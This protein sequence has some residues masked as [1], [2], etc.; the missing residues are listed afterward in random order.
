MKHVSHIRYLHQRYIPWWCTIKDLQES[1]ILQ[2]SN[3]SS[4][5]AILQGRFRL[6]RFERF[7]YPPTPALVPLLRS[8]SSSCRHGCSSRGREID[9]IGP[10][11]T[12]AEGFGL[13]LSRISLKDFRR[14][15]GGSGPPATTT[16]W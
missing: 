8:P 3:F 4:S 13:R 11:F 5:S 6:S 12:A 14:V 10:G 9:P 1:T 15:D 2:P 16:T 7:T